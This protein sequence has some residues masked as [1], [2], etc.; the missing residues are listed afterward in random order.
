M[1]AESSTLI[2]FDLETGGPNPDRHPIIQIAA[3][4]LDGATLSTLETIELKVRFDERQATKYA[5]RKNAYSRRTWK[6]Q[7]LPEV[8]VARL[9]AEFLR[10]HATHIALSQNGDEYRLAQLVAHNAAFDGAFLH[11]WY[12]RLT[13]FCP[14][15]HQVLCTLQ[16]A[17]WYFA[18]RPDLPRPDN[19]KLQTLCRYFS[20]P[21]HPHDAH[22]A[23]ADVRAT[24][25]LYRALLRDGSDRI[26]EPQPLRPLRQTA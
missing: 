1:L 5:L 17:E 13:I 23:L 22:E 2:F 3:A 25:G 10:R 24:V 20:V 26:S 9:L 8:E 21:L 19:F 7:A 14:A 4:A 12:K 6:D 18:E 11:A 16:R 15:R